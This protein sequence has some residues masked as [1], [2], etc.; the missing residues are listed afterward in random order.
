M[1]TRADEETLLVAQL[2]DEV[3]YLIEDLLFDYT[4]AVREGIDQIVSELPGH[5]PV[6]G[7]SFTSG[8]QAMLIAARAKVSA[9]VPR[10]GHLAL[11][12]V[13]HALR[14]AQLQLAGMPPAYPL[15]PELRVHV[16]PVG[17]P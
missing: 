12:E 13:R 5:A 9:Y 2:L 7:A 4:N 17:D 11:I 3:T 15:P 1:E 6:L 10:E 16:V 14:N 8:L